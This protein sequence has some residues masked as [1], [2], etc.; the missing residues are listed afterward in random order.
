MP[1]SLLIT[2]PGRFLPVALKPQRR[3]IDH[4]RHTQD[5]RKAHP[6]LAGVNAHLARVPSGRGLL[7]WQAAVT[8]R[9]NS[10]MSKASPNNSCSNWP[11]CA[12]TRTSISLYARVSSIQAK[13]RLIRRCAAID[14]SML[15]SSAHLIFVLI[16]GRYFFLPDGRR[17]LLLAAV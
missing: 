10:V 5:E 6:P 9:S 14:S 15:S 16:C 12:V 8:T 1:W 17:A 2:A 4:Q 13:I 7:S 3:H 11:K